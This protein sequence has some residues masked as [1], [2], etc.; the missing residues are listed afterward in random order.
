M[1]TD[2][3]IS[4]LESTSTAAITAARASL[5]Y[6]IMWAVVYMALGL[7]V[8]LLAYT[9]YHFTH[10]KEVSDF[11]VSFIMMVWPIVLAFMILDMIVTFIHR[12]FLNIY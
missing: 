3:G 1:N 10:K 4:G 2:I 7:F 12:W 6:G 9:Y 8:G 5:G 11:A